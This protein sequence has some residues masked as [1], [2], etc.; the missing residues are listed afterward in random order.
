VLST[1]ITAVTLSLFTSFCCSL[2]EAVLYTISTSQVEMLKKGGHRSADLLTALRTDINRP[3]TAIL[4]M[5]TVA[6]TVG[7]TVAGVSA[8]SLFGEQ[9]LIYFSAVF[10]LTILIF[11]E[12]IPKTIGVNY[13][14]L[15]APL[16]ARPLAALV[17]VLRPV[18]WLCQLVTRLIPHNEEGNHVSAEELRTIATLS[19]Q[20]G[21]IGADQER[22]INNILELGNKTVRQIMTPRTVTFSLEKETTIAEA[23]QLDEHLRHYSRIPL[24]HENFNETTGIVLYKDILRAAAQG[25]KDLRLAQIMLP[26]H[27]VPETAPLN[28]VL[29]EF[30]ERNQHLFVVVD[31]YGAMTGVISLE[32]ILEEIVGREIMDES[33][34]ARN[35]RELAR[36]QYQSASLRSGQKE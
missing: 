19:L 16:I 31:E 5:N 23:M 9:H 20:S 6:N 2:F 13:A 11:S 30:F 7:A 33:D 32:D 34:R 26:V 18:I 24:Y 14:V 22:V 1:F 27:F 25:N 15:L 35:M 3:I 17:V 36:R 29:M 4:T 10:T 21:Q 8:A 28:R 12:I